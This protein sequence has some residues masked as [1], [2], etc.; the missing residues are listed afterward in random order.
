YMLEVFPLGDALAMVFEGSGECAE[1]VWRFLGLSMPAWVLICLLSLG[2]V[3]LIGNWRLHG[4]LREQSR[5]APA[6]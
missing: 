1:V 4:R 2:L 3:G 6:G 5:T